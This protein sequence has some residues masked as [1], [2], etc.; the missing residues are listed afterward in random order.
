MFEYRHQLCWTNFPMPLHAQRRKCWRQDRNWLPKTHNPEVSEMLVDPCSHGRRTVTVI[1]A[2]NSESMT[3]WCCFWNRWAIHYSTELISVKGYMSVNNKLMAVYIVIY[4]IWTAAKSL[5][6]NFLLL[7]VH[8]L[9]V[10]SSSRSISRKQHEALL[11]ENIYV[12]I[13]Y[14]F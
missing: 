6:L 5:D 11:E 3:A 7:K 14:K 2:L 9:K 12:F 13:I 4:S 1:I 10:L 8:S